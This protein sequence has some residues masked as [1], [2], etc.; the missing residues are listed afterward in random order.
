MTV[1]KKHADI[2][3]LEQIECAIYEIRGE[4][5][6]LVSDLAW[7]YGVPTHRLNKQVRRNI[8]RFPE[9]FRFT[10]SVQEFKALR[11]QN[12]ISKER[13]GGLASLCK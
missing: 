6:I 7:L 10:L 12:A 2:L 5:V 11:S 1:K 3:V 4:R 8:H 9:D 13:H